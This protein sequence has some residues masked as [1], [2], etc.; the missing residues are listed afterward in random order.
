MTVESAPDA[1]RVS[2]IGAPTDIGASVIGARLGP[3]ALRVAGIERAL[4]AFGNDVV[5]AVDR[6][7]P[8]HPMLPPVH[9]YRHL[10][11]VV[12]WTQSL[13]DACDC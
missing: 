9:G 13:D 5:D 10:P 3:G 8:D 1:R 12:G 2:L 6:V 7:G 11:D 4:A